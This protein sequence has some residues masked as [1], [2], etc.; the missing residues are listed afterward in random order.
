MKHTSELTINNRSTFGDII[1]WLFGIV[2]MAIG[3]INTFWS[4]DPVYGVFILF[5]SFVYFP[6]TNVFLKNISGISITLKVKIL[7]GIF[8]FWTALG[9]GEL[10]DK[11][12]LMIN[13]LQYSNS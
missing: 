11:I 12:D 5:L 10:F 1:S 8:I 7:L 3:I 13:D 4:N 6:L 9:V 2:I